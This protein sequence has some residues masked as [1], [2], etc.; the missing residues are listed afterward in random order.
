MFSVKIRENGRDRFVGPYSMAQEA[1]QVAT[2]YWRRRVDAEVVEEPV[3]SRTEADVSGIFQAVGADK[4]EHGYS[5]VYAAV[6]ED[7]ELV[8]EIGVANGHS[9]K[10]WQ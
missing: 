2:E 7:I 6:P 9:M 4:F 3:K 10:A 1:A 5:K 8:M